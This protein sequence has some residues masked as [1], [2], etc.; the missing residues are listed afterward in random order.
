[1]ANEP[2]NGENGDALERPRL[3]AQMGRTRDEFEVR[4]ASELLQRL[5][6]ELDNHEIVTAG[7]HQGGAL[8]TLSARLA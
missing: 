3:F 1:M 4:F 5:T 7:D 6:F 2:V 8:T